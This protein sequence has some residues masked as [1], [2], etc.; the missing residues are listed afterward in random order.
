MSMLVAGTM[1]LLLPHILTSS[2]ICMV[3]RRMLCDEPT[4]PN[5]AFTC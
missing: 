5:T 2:I 4:W 1:V 3:E